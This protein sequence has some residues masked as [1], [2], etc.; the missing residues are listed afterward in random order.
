MAYDSLNFRAGPKSIVQICNKPEKSKGTHQ[1]HLGIHFLFMESIL[2][3]R[4][5]APHG[6][7]IAWVH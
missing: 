1:P 5:Q 7:N 2:T 3:K 4:F 6:T